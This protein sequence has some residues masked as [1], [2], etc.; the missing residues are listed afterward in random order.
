MKLKQSLFPVFAAVVVAAPMIA[1]IASYA[2]IP[3]HG[4][5]IYRSWCSVNN[6]YGD[7]MWDDDPYE[8]WMDFDQMTGEITAHCKGWNQ[9][10]YTPYYNH[11]ITDCEFKVRDE[12]VHGYGWGKAK[13]GEGIEVNCHGFVPPNF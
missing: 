5:K 11:E 12:V 7:L 6:Y 1:P 4:A 13:F 8:F 2:G 3:P 9:S 10:G